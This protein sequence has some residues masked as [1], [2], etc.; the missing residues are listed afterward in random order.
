MRALLH[1]E[2]QLRR[3]SGRRGYVMLV[4]LILM[5]ILSVVGA[6]T[7]SVASTDQRIA[8]HNRK[9]MMVLNTASAGTEHARYELETT[10]PPNEGVDSAGDTYPDFVTAEDAE[11]D[12]GGLAYTH[13]LGVYWVSAVYQRCGYPPPGY[14][15]EIGRNQFR[16]DYW[17]MESTARMQ[18]TSYNN[19]NETQANASSLIRKVLR[20]TCKIR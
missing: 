9:H 17:L 6:T 2:G 14:S 8:V 1:Q 18:D 19:V 13:N 16:A 4:A 3:V 7:L 15:T 5:A 20:G 11:T 10:N 12:F